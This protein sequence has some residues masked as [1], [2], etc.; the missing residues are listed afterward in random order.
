MDSIG[1]KDEMTVTP[2][3]NMNAAIWEHNCYMFN[4]DVLK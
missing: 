2:V 3:M 1:S 4:V